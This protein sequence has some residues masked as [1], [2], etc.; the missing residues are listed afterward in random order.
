[1]IGKD[2]RLKLTKFMDLNKTEKILIFFYIILVISFISAVFYFDLQY[3]EQYPNVMNSTSISFLTPIES[4]TIKKTVDVNSESLFLAISDIEEYSYVLPKNVK[5][6][7][8]LSSSENENTVRHVLSEQGITTSIVSKHH[9]IPFESYT[10]EI[11]EGDAKGTIISI[12]L[13]ENHEKTEIFAKIDFEFSGVLTPF[14][15][16]PEQNLKHAFDT[17][18]DAFVLY[19]KA[20]ADES[21]T[22]VDRLYREILLRPAD[23]EGLNHYSNLL[24]T[25][26]ITES[27]LR[28]ELMNSEER[29]YLEILDNMKSVD[30]LDNETKMIIE[31]LYMEIL[32][33]NVDEPGLEY[34]GNMLENEMMSKNEI[35]QSLLASDE[36]QSIEIFFR[37]KP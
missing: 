22:T 36:Y 9:A 24:K 23:L 27:Q 37:E 12:N 5:S 17:V 26:Q 6:S 35:R 14:V 1:M 13:E 15:Y 29:K 7:E 10:I 18:L 21:K 11:I 34:Y 25:N 20:S 33:R 32:R 19:A 4:I 30:E 31:D 8:I 3:R 28:V 2:I 16:L